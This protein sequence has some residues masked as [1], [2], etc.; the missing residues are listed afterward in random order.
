MDIEKEL[1]LT[2]D[3]KTKFENAKG[4]EEIK[5]QDTV[6]VDYSAG[7][8]GKNLALAVS[9]EK[10]EDLDTVPADLPEPVKERV[11]SAPDESAVAPPAVQA[12]PEVQS[13]APA[14]KT[15]ADQS[16]PAEVKQ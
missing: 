7:S 3:D 12:T 2:V 1:T 14:A 11:G 9:V 13:V 16:A 4:L 8:D 10:L 5:A 15:D 6:S